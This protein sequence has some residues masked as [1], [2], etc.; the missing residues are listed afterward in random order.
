MSEN[1]HNPT[2]VHKVQS[3]LSKLFILSC[4][5]IG[6]LCAFVSAQ[7]DLDAL[8]DPNQKSVIEMIFNY[9]HAKIK[10]NS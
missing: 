5:I 1:N 6:G 7:I 4:F 3:K 2:S 10:N 9:E 8:S